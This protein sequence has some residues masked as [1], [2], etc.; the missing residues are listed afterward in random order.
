MGC[1]MRWNLAAFVLLG[2]LVGC[3]QRPAEKSGEGAADPA[4]QAAATW[5]REGQRLQAEFEAALAAEDYERAFQVLAP[6]RSAMPA[7]L[8]G[9]HRFAER[10]VQ[11]MG[12]IR[13]AKAAEERRAAEAR[14]ALAQAVLRE[15]DALIGPEPVPSPWDGAY[16]EVERYLE[17]V[18][19]D[20]DSLDFDACTLPIQSDEG[21]RVTCEYRARNGFGALR[22]QSGVFVIRHGE[23]V[24]QLD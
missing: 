2:V 6:V 9:R 10:Q 18:L 20:P 5:A 19:H 8:R 7:E 16:Y 13:A 14:D 21:W 1:G 11:R 12:E 4:A 23:V 15:R 17:R 3:G 24:A 22:R